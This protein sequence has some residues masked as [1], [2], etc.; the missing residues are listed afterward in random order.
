MKEVF[1]SRSVRNE[2]YRLRGMA[3]KSDRGHF[4]SANNELSCNAMRV[5]KPDEHVAKG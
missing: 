1:I 4:P 2:R 3:T 5:N